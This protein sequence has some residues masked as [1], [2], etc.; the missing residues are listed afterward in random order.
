MLPQAALMQPV[1]DLRGMQ[2]LM[3]PV[4]QM[5]GMQRLAMLMAMMVLGSPQ[6]YG[7]QTPE[8]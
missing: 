8:V 2:G 5:D 7:C 4:M 3:Q 1:A 6:V